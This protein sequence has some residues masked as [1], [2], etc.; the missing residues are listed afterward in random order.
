MRRRRASRR[1]RGLL[2]ASRS[3]SGCLLGASL[4]AS[5]GVLGACWWSRRPLGA[6]WVHLGASLG[7]LGRPLPESKDGGWKN[8]LAKPLTPSRASGI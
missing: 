5:C 2:D 8:K 1:A 3:L 6:S 4:E 7:P